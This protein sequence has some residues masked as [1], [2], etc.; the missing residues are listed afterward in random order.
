MI[1]PFALGLQTIHTKEMPT[2]GYDLLSKKEVA[3][4][5]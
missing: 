1:R 2:R 4:L 3:H 5:K